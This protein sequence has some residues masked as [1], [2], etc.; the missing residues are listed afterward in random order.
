MKTF[1]KATMGSLRMLKA[2]GGGEKME[3]EWE[4]E[5]GEE[6]TEDEEWEE[7]EW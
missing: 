5:G 7:E 1:K 3:E 2:Y 4:E 6:G